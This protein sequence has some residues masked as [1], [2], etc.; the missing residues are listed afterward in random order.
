MTRARLTEGSKELVRGIF[1][2][3]PHQGGRRGR[4]GTFFGLSKLPGGL[5][6]A[7][8]AG[9]SLFELNG[10][11]LHIEFIRNSNWGCNA[12]GQ[13]ENIGKPFL[14]TSVV[15]KTGEVEVYREYVGGGRG[16]IGTRGRPEY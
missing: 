15:T 6:G 13:G 9:H 5:L 3:V 10:K 14:W 11:D 1:T 12:H 8:C 16:N 7:C 4:G 2:L